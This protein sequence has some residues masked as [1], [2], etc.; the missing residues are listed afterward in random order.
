MET[1]NRRPFPL[2][3]DAGSIDDDVAFVDKSRSVFPSE[4]NMPQAFKIV[5]LCFDNFGIE[6]N[7]R[8]KV[9]FFVESRKV[10]LDL[11]PARVEFAS[12]MLAYKS[13]RLKPISHI[14]VKVERETRADD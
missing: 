1:I 10:V 6:N 2:C 11:L 13:G 5:P 3:Q 9:M 14:K 4:S 8:S 12:P 7:K